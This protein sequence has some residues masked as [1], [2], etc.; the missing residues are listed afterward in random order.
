MD[1]TTFLRRVNVQIRFLF[2]SS[3]KLTEL[4]SW[5]GWLQTYN[6]GRVTTDTEKP[7]RRQTV[8]RTVFKSLNQKEYLD[9]SW[10]AEQ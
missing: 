9:L 3:F 5:K 8:K 7:F 6:I 10:R 2:T 1:L 4:L